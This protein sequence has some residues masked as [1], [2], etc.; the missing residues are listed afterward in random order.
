M[1]SPFDFLRTYPE[2]WRVLCDVVS[3]I[4]DVTIY[5]GDNPTEPFCSSEFIE[6]TATAN[7]FDQLISWAEQYGECFDIQMPHRKSKT[8]TGEKK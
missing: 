5:Y 6:G 1:M 3:P 2:C 8:A 7:D 4:I